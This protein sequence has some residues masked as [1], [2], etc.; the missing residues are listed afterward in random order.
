MATQ[1]F[2]TIGL[3]VKVDGTS[4]NYVTDIGDI[5]A[6][7]SELDAT[8]MKDSMKKT[9]P[10]VQDAAAF[11][12]TFLFDNSAPDSDYRVLRALQDAGETVELEVKFPD[13][14]VFAATGY[15]SVMVS[16]AAV[17]EL[18]S[19]KLTFNL[20]SDWTVTNPSAASGQGG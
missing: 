3:D 2:S 6:A 15:V 10:G 4:L 17:D 5:G 12:V 18:V 20:Q 1:G 8:C 9:V 13:G 16:G 11:E 19:A 14:T 7:P